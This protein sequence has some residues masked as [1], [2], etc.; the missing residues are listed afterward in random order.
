[1]PLSHEVVYLQGGNKDNEDAFVADAVT[2]IYAVI[3]GATGLGGLSGKMA[4]EVTRETIASAKADEALI[5]VLKRANTALAC[6][7][8]Q[9]EGV[10]SLNAIPKEERSTCGF[11]VLR[12]RDH[13]L[14][15][16]HA[17]DCMI[18]VLN[19]AGDIRILTHDHLSSLDAVSIQQFRSEIGRRLQGAQNPNDWDENTIQTLL[20][21][22][23]LVLLPTLIHNRRRLNT[24]DGYGVLDGSPEAI[25][26]FDHGEI[27]LLQADKILML[28]DGLQLPSAKGAGQKAWR[29]TAEYAF[30]HGLE[31]LKDEVIRIENEDKACFH[32]PRLKFADDKTGIMIELDKY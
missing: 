1:M 9:Q 30:Q 25:H 31:A 4:A 15:Y 3:D 29:E 2:G 11:A 19:K 17:G 16:I 5:D 28:S 14:E 32:Y 18:F 21:E 12:A 8:T 27:S 7:I 20:H 6:E 23:R 26:F 10:S 13:R 24:K 22:V